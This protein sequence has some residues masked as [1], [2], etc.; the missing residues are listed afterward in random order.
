MICIRYWFRH[1]R[2]G[3]RCSP[4]RIECCATCSL[5]L[6]YCCFYLP[7]V[8]DFSEILQ[9]YSCLSLL[10]Q[11]YGN[12]GLALLLIFLE[13]F[14]Y[15]FYF[16]FILWL[17][18]FLVLY[19]RCWIQDVIWLLFLATIIPEHLSSWNISRISSKNLF[20]K[21]LFMK[22]KFWKIWPTFDY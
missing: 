18:T 3:I 1:F 19:L 17:H 6:V 12:S 8:W 10:I 21:F 20:W 22:C 5:S 15:I 2:C 16:F 9:L 7:I 14:Y 11:L 13:P 4:L